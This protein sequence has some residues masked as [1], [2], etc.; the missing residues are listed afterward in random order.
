MKIPAK[1]KAAIDTAR[2]IVYLFNEKSLLADGSF[3]C[4]AGCGVRGPAVN[5]ASQIQFHDCLTLRLARGLVDFADR[6]KKELEK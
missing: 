1:T 2:S 3:S 5:A 6:V 4:A